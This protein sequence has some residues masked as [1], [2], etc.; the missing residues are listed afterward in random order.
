MGAP[1]CPENANPA[2]YMLQAIRCGPET[3]P[4][5]DWATIWQESREFQA[6]RAHL[7]ELRQGSVSSTFADAK[8]LHS[9]KIT[10]F[11]VPFSQQCLQVTRRVFQQYWRTPSYIFSKAL[12]LIG[13][14]S[15]FAVFFLSLVSICRVTN[16][17]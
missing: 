17:S 13:A 11:A 4:E 15:L 10:E 5:V 6:V 7:D 16:P 12:L 1:P 2:E 3:R 9:G 8:A 14:V